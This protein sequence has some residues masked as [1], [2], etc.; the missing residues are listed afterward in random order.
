VI[1][2]ASRSAVADQPVEHP[3]VDV[4]AERAVRDALLDHPQP[5]PLHLGRRR[6]HVGEALLFAKVL[7]LVLINGG[8]VGLLIRDGEGGAHQIV[9]SLLRG[10]VFVENLGVAGLDRVQ[11]AGEDLLDDGI[12]G[13]KM[14]IQAAGQHADGVGNL[15]DGGRAEALAGEHLRGAG[16]DQPATIRLLGHEG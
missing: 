15:T 5:D 4:V 6:Q 13:L 8:G 2:S 10:G 14:V 11:I 7:K 1:C 12:L 9:Q 16:Q 3:R